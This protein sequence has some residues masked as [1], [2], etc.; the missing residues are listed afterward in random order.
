MNAQY[1]LPLKTANDEPEH[2]LVGH[3]THLIYWISDG[4]SP[5]SSHNQPTSA[6]DVAES[7]LI[8]AMQATSLIAEQKARIAQLEEQ[9][10]TDE[11]TQLSNRRG[12]LREVRRVRSAMERYDEQG[13][14]LYIDLDGFKQINDTFGHAAGDAVLQRVAEVLRDSVRQSDAVARLGGDEFAVLLSHASPEAARSKARELERVL[15]GSK[16]WWHDRQIPIRAS[17]GIRKVTRNCT[18]DKL[19]ND[20]D[21]DM[22]ASKRTRCSQPPALPLP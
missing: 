17:I 14:L 19:L 15:N 3:I 13:L 11:L 16:A 1:G 18:M 8:S 7:A 5:T 6:F 2:D 9:V 20:A 4:V 12:F 10:M 21:S 22:Y